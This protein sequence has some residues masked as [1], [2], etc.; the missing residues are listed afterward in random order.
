MLAKLVIEVLGLFERVRQILD[1][2]AVACVVAALVLCIGVFVGSA[3][4]QMLE[5]NPRTVCHLRVQVRL[6]NLVVQSCEVCF[7]RGLFEERL[8]YEKAILVFRLINT[9]HV[10]LEVCVPFDRDVA[11]RVG[12]D[13][14]RHGGWPELLLIPHLHWNWPFDIVASGHTLS[15]RLHHLS[16]AELFWPIAPAQAT[17]V[18]D[19]V[20][21]NWHIERTVCVWVLRDL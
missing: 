8:Q 9:A 17:R 16:H 19:H 18:V 5:P 14:M 20:D 3:A 1:V 4:V 6:F 15:Q 2:Q 13:G 12:L 11:T 7:S 10:C 21:H